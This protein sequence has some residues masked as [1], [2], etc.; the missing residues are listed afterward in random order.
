MPSMMITLDRGSNSIWPLEQMQNHSWLLSLNWMCSTMK[1]RMSKHCSLSCKVTSKNCKPLA[2][3]GHT[4][5]LT[6][7]NNCVSPW[8]NH[9]WVQ[10]GDAEFHHHLHRSHNGRTPRQGYGLPSSWTFFSVGAFFLIKKQM[11]CR[12]LS[13][14]QARVMGVTMGNFSLANWQ[15]NATG[16]Q[17]KQTLDRKWIEWNMFEQWN[18]C[19][20]I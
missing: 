4:V 18:T 14:R 13:I 15:G 20:L 16:C 2:L 17:H 8:C 1:Q 3:V 11:G 5:S 12:G 9:C 10:H 6:K 19:S 7:T